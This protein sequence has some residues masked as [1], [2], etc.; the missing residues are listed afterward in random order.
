MKTKLFGRHV[1]N[2]GYL[3]LYGVYWI[4]DNYF[5]IIDRRCDGVFAF[6]EYQQRPDTNDMDDD[7]WRG[8]LEKMDQNVASLIDSY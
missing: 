3:F 2:R 7:Q 8:V 5:N 4:D 1:I 6:V